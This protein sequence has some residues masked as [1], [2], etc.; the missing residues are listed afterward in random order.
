[1]KKMYTVLFV[2]ATILVSINSI[3]LSQT[4]LGFRGGL[5]LANISE[6]LGGTETFD[7]EGEPLEITLTQSSRTTFNIGG[8]VE[9]WFS[10]MFALQINILYNQ[11]GAVIDGDLNETIIEQGIEINVTA[12]AEQELKLSYLS[13]PLLA[14]VAFGESNIKPYLIAGPEIG[15][16]L[17]AENVAEATAKAEAMGQTFGPYTTSLEEDVKDDMET[18]ELALDFGAGLSFSF[19]N[20]E[21]FADF[22]Y[23]LGITKI[24]K[25]EFIEGEDVKNQNIMLNLGM[26]F[27]IQ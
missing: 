9:Y 13:F 8:F 16:L 19:G 27:S 17:S 22:I 6:D 5:N 14:K 25:E 3:G 20:I 18:I 10:P 21:V 24:N 4:K 1:M 2:I 7:F 11:K 15:F 23:S 26:I 12:N